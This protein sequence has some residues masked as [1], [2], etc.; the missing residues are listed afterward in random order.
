[1]ESDTRPAPSQ[2]A[3]AVRDDPGCDRRPIADA[4]PAPSSIAAA[5]WQVVPL[6]WRIPT[7]QRPRSGA[8]RTTT[9][10]CASPR[11]TRPPIPSSCAGCRSATS[12]GA[13]APRGARAPSTTSPSVSAWRWCAR[14]RPA[15]SACWISAPATAGWRGAWPDRSASPRWTWT[16]ATQ[17]W[18]RCATRRVARVAGDL[19][20]LPL[21]A[22][23]FDAVVAAASLHYAVDVRAVLAEAARVLRPGG[24]LIVA[25]S[26]VYD[27]DAARDGGLA[28]D[29]RPLR[30][31]RAP[32]TWRRAIAVSRARSSTPPAHSAS[33][34]AVP[35]M[36]SWRS[37]LAR[38]APPARGRA[39]TRA[40]RLAALTA[41]EGA[42]GG[43]VRSTGAPCAGRSPRS[44][45]RRTATS[46]DRARCPRRRSPPP[47]RPAP[48]PAGSRPRTRG[49]SRSSCRRKARARTADRG[50]PA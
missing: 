42:A 25:D 15:P 8:S 46:C 7:S 4:V 29:P 22:R 19:E 41:P 35:G 36:M 39:P 47:S 14:T 37:V 26:P 48:A 34:P 16:P 31:V 17:V 43:S 5:G 27:D 49:S 38:M 20:A 2:D 9:G 45:P 30:V 21:R 13:T 32:R 23:S 6:P 33:S 18:A 28:A 24:V 10:G 1:M 12:P 50:S 44:R 40:V 3:A 11:G